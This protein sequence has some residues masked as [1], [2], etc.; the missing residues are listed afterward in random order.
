MKK[1]SALF[2][3]GSTNAV[4]K[5]ISPTMIQTPSQPA[6]ITLWYVDTFQALWI[7]FS[8]TN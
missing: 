3:I 2:K 5:M 6:P 8:L 4:I 7:V 1:Q